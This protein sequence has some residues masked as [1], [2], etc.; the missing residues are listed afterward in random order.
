MPGIMDAATLEDIGKSRSAF[1][2]NAPL[3]EEEVMAVG[4]AMTLPA[5]TENPR[6][7]AAAVPLLKDLDLAE[8][9]D[10][11]DVPVAHDDYNAAYAHYLSC[12]ALTALVAFNEGWEALEKTI[13]K[14]F[15]AARRAENAEYRGDDPNRAFSLRVRQQ[16][17]E[18]FLL[19]IRSSVQE[20]KATPRPV[21]KK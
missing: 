5:I 12:Q 3:T 14:R 20:A 18:D 19:F 17:A 16:A 9:E 7:T 4:M 21:L 15:V 6:T 11:S 1:D 2:I 10:E 13:L 8:E